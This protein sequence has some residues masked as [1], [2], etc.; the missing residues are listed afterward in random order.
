MRRKSYLLF[1]TVVLFSFGASGCLPLSLL[2]SGD[3][4]T[5]KKTGKKSQSKSKSENNPKS[6][7]KPGEPI[8]LDIDKNTDYINVMGKEMPEMPEFDEPSPEPGKVCGYV[9][10]LAGNPLKGAQLGVRSTAIGGAYSGSQG[11]TDD[12][13]YYEF[14]V[15]AGVAHFYNAGY[16]IE[17]GEDGLAA[18]G[19]HPADGKLDSFAS[20]TGGVENFVLLPYGVTS[21]ENTQ[22]SP[23]LA[24]TY[25]GG[26]VYFSYYAAEA[27][28]NYPMEGS[29]ILGS[30]IEITLTPEGEMFGGIEPTSFTVR[31][32]IGYRGGFYINNIPLGQYRIEVKTSDGEP[33]KMELNKPRNSEYGI[34]PTE[35]TDGA[36]LTFAPSDARANM[37]TPQYGGWSAVEINVSRP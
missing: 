2:N 26:S 3:Q 22:Q 28:D 20:T 17:W 32:T 15:P 29:V 13:G 19:L 4:K 16:A 27:S 34:K 5:A 8:A 35:T 9:K 12:D 31:K 14:E 1:L 30:V 24:S 21:R 33:L 6:N 11:E 25:Y 37:V 7:R 18:M 10:D 36:V 23:H